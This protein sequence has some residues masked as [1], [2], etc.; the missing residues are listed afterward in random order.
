MTRSQNQ[1]ARLTR[2]EKKVIATL[3]AGKGSEN[4]LKITE[5]SVELYTNP[6]LPASASLGHAVGTCKMGVD[7]LAVGGCLTGT[8][9][10]TDASHFQTNRANLEAAPCG[11][12]SLQFL[13]RLARKLHDGTALKA[14][15]GQ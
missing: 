13:E 14:G 15:H 5:K 2:S 6:Y 11:H 1:A 7:K 10:F 12:C 8:A 4:R 3:I 9:F